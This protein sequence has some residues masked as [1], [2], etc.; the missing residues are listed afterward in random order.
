V[1]ARNFGSDIDSTVLDKGFEYLKK[2]QNA[3]GSFHYVQG[4]GQSM[5]GGTAAGVGT[6]ALMGKFDFKVMINSYK[7]LLKFTPKGMSS[8]HGPYYSPYYGH[9]YA[10]MGMHLVGQ[11]YKEDKEF[12]DNT[13][14]YVAETQKE[15]V[16]WQQKDGSWQN[17]GWLKDNEKAESN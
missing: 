10:S 3:D 1:S 2:C 12:R 17:R 16:D 15:L 8:L 7:D 6:L 11:E 13:G 14:R 9:Y 4:D 5:K